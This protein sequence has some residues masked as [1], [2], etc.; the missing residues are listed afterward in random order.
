MKYF[1]T[2]TL[3]LAMGVCGLK[4]QKGTALKTNADSLGY[5]IG[6]NIAAD[7]KKNGVNPN[8]DALLEGLKASM[9]GS[10]TSM[11][12]QQMRDVLN[13]F[14][15]AQQA[16]IAAEK[17]AKSDAN[18]KKGQDFLAQNKS[19][20][21]IKVLDNGLQYEVITEGTGASPKSTDKVTTHYRGTLIDGTEFDSSYKRGQPATFPVNGVIQAWQIILPMMKEG[22]KVKIYSPSN[23]AYGPSGQGPTIGP[24]E[25]LIFDIELIK[26][27]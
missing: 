14:Q 6:M 25:V 13:R 9:A 16:K 11:T 7:F 21:G 20:P 27:N 15:Q 17:K 23:L 19:K 3:L 24:N 5:A 18:M 8:L 26:V 12:D 10:E 2:L 4:A 1:L 22:G